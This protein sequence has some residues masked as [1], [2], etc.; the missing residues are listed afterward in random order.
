MSA[1]P[2]PGSFTPFLEAWAAASAPSM[3]ESPAVLSPAATPA[4]SAG[5]AALPP[6]TG[7][8]IAIIEILARQPQLTLP[9]SDLQSLSG[10]DATRYRDALKS[11]RARDYVVVDGPPLDEVIRLTPKGAEAASL[12]RL[13]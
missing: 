11:L 2:N 1:K 8:P 3:P 12:A 6:W 13:A 4:A 7:S 9:L 5:A 10:M